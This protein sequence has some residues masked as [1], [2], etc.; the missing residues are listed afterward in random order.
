MKNKIFSIL[1][2]I[3]L[4]LFFSCKDETDTPQLAAD[5]TVDKQEVTAEGTV[6][7]TDASTGN[8]SRWNWTF[9]G[10]TPQTSVLSSPAVVYKTPGTYPVKL[11]VG[12]AGDSVS[13]T[14]EA[15]ITVGY[16]AVTADFSASETTVIQGQAITFTDMSKGR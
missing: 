2:V 8:P 1:S 7:F 11:M 4:V 10:G 12:S 3:L 9:E 13:I 16:G 14:K 6:N 5:F 15:F